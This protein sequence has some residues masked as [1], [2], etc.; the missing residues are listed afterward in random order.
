MVATLWPDLISAIAICMATV[1][2]P[3]PPF[4]FPTTMTRAGRASV[5]FSRDMNALQ[6]VVDGNA[7]NTGVISRGQSNMADLDRLRVL[8]SLISASFRYKF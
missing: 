1:D 7:S 2:L 6:N 3:D 8:K 5:A 4:S